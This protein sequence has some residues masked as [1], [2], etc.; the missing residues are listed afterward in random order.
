M[1]GLLSIISLFFT[2]W[3]VFSK[4]KTTQVL[5]RFQASYH[6]N[7]AAIGA[8]ATPP[9][10]GNGFEV[11]VVGVQE[12][13]VATDDLHSAPISFFTSTDT[14]ITTNR[15]SQ[16]LELID[17]ELPTALVRTCLSMHSVC[18]ISALYPHIY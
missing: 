6:Q 2:C 14:G 11:S 7:G 8:R 13:S 9:I 16:D 1:F 5:I 15:F 10:A 17:M 3:S 12:S 18:A 4:A